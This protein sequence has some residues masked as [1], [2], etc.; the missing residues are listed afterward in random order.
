MTLWQKSLVVTLHMLHITIIVFC[1]VGWLLPPARP[2]HL[3]L[4]VLILVLTI[5]AL[6]FFPNPGESLRPGS[7]VR[8]KIAGRRLSYAARAWRVPSRWLRTV[9]W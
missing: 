8:A 5:V 3:M 6:A 7:P 2:W 1:V 9:F 4:C